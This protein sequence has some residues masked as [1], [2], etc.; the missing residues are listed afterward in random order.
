MAAAALEG[1]T[2][3]FVN[4][5]AVQWVLNFENA[6]ELDQRFNFFQRHF[7]VELRPSVVIRCR[8][9]ADF[10]FALRQKETIED[11]VKEFEPFWNLFVGTRI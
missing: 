11:H 3:G 4:R 10:R 1:G 8:I 5:K 9:D 6:L 7:V 2:C